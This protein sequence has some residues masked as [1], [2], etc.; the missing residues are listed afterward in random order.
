MN[1]HQQLAELFEGLAHDLGAKFDVVLDFGCGA[2]RLVEALSE[3][4]ATAYGCDIASYLAPDL[5]VP[6]E[7]FAQ[8]EF[9]PYR[10]P[11][12]DNFFDA[13]ISTSVL[14]HAQNTAEVFSEIRRV[15]K[16]GGLSLHL[17]PA[18][19][20]LPSEN[21][22]HVPLANFFWPR[23]PLWWLKLWAHLGVRN[24][25][26]RGK[27]AA[28]VAR[29][30]AR[31]CRDNLIY[32]STAEYDRL[33]QQVFGNSAWPMRPYLSRAVGGVAKAWRLAPFKRP[34]EWLSREC[35]MRV[36]AQRKP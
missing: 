27:P 23:V 17:F 13:V 9:D 11:Y 4:G 8:L 31:F 5:T 36:L 34:V 24:E 3:R 16:P 25:F 26:Q 15:L 32:L 21:H 28:E 30:N 29:L 22:I 35:R 7:R 18:R 10:F 14:E 12:P 6:A 33:S 2:G 19:W 20:Y 1:E